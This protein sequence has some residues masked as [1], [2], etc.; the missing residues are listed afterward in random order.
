MIID[1]HLQFKE[2]QIDRWRKRARKIY[3]NND[4]RKS[5]QNNNKKTKKKNRKEGEKQN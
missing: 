3:I 4:N 5:Y 2:R 1:I